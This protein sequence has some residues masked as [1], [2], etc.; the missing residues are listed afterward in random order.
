[1]KRELDRNSSE[2]GETQ[3]LLKVFLYFMH[4]SMFWFFVF[5][6][7]II[8]AIVG[9]RIDNRL[10]HGVVATSWAP[11]SNATRVMVIDD[12]VASDPQKKQAMKLGRPS[13]MAV[14]IITKQTALDHFKAHKYDRQRVF[15]VSQTPDVFLD[16]INQGE[17]IDQIVLGGTLTFENAIKVTKRAYIKP[18]Q[19]DIYKK[20]LS[21]GVHIVSQYVPQDDAVDVAKVLNRN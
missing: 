8:M 9:A 7:G 11:D 15:I 6:G 1:M 20:L 16:L 19:V 12:A 4:R 3:T 14:S 17:Q 18:E 5:S 21:K 13:G 2:T 10:L